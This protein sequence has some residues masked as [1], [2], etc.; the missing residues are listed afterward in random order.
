MAS[1]SIMPLLIGTL[2]GGGQQGGGGGGGGGCEK[3]GIANNTQIIRIISSLFLFL[4]NIVCFNWYV[5]LYE[6]IKLAI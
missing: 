3:T 1:I 4:L 6:I 2:H 5:K